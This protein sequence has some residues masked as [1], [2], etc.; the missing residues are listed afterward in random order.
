M[1][2]QTDKKLEGKVAVITGA[3][4]GIG[5]AVAIG[6]AQEGCDLVL[7][8]RD[9]AGLEQTAQR[10]RQE[11]RTVLVVPTDV[12]DVEQVK[13]FVQKVAEKFKHIDILFNGASASSSGEDT[14]RN[15][16][17]DRIF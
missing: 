4:Y 5:R 15:L 13:A 10:I 7:V 1:T 8:A 6:L 2:A 11:G 12:G 3:S 16:D 9:Q 17:Y 14:L